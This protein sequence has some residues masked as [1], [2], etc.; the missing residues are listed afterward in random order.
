[1]SSL[2]RKINKSIDHSYSISISP[3]QRLE[4]KRSNLIQNF[5]LALKLKHSKY[6]KQKRY[7]LKMLNDDLKELIKVSD[8]NSFDYTNWMFKLEKEIFNKLSSVNNLPVD[9]T[10]KTVNKTNNNTNNTNNNTNNNSINYGIISNNISISESQIPNTLPNLKHKSMNNSID[11]NYLES[12][13]FNDLFLDNKKKK[14]LYLRINEK[15]E[16]GL[17][18]KQDYQDFI[19]EKEKIKQKQHQKS[20]AIKE[21]LEKQIIEKRNAEINKKNSGMEWKYKIESEKL[22]YENS[23]RE[24]QIKI[25]EQNIELNKYRMNEMLEHK[26]KEKDLE[27][28]EKQFDK[29]Y[30][31]NA[32]HEIDNEREK[33]MIKREREKEFIRNLDIFI[34]KKHI[35]ETEENKKNKLDDSKIERESL[36][37]LNKLDDQRKKLFMRVKAKVDKM[38]SVSGYTYKEQAKKNKENLKIQKEKI[39]NDTK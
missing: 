30:L 2:K 36:E 11:F 37:I 14:L 20:R 21:L 10:R 13:E 16:W 33:S 28:K 18:I 27:A 8:I 19:K 3:S 9:N 15:E 31:I 6:F 1:M 22:K 12:S 23:E 26:L 29:K 35:I 5:S 32:Q 4:N 25:K 39:L 17:K 7:T 24:K 38:E 34:E